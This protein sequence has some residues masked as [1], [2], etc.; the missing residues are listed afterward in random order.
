MKIAIVDDKYEDCEQLAAMVERYCSRRSLPLQI[1]FFSSGDDMLKTFHTG[2]YQ[3]MFLDIYMEGTDG[4]EIAREIYQRDPAC[5]LIFS[6]VSVSHAVSSYEVHAAWYLTKP[7]SEERLNDAMDAAC[8]NLLHSS[9]SI[10]I[11]VGYTNLTI[12]HEDIF[13]MDCS[14]RQARIHLKDRVL[15][16]NEPISDLIKLL[17]RD[18]RFLMC[19]RNTLVNMDHIELAEEQDFLLKNGDLVPLRQRGRAT[20]KKAFLA[21]SLRELRREEHR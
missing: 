7:I 16:A 21:W 19:N 2:D 17:S 20:L 9:R 11:H 8:Q 14:N 5:R 18:E 1:V 3:C 12:R 6:T 10:S 15:F 4:M 13:F